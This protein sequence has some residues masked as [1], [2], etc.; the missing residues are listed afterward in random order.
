ML[1]LFP[2]SKEHPRLKTDLVW[3]SAEGRDI[4]IAK[5]MSPICNCGRHK[6]QERGTKWTVKQKRNVVSQKRNNAATRGGVMKGGEDRETDRRRE[7]ERET[8]DKGRRGAEGRGVDT[9]KRRRMWNR[10]INY[11]RIN[12]D[13][14]V[15]KVHILL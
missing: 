13:R 3:A 8:T 4:I 9:G 7:R 12:D 10:G 11:Q 6:G 1:T 15:K 14:S 2:T 5:A